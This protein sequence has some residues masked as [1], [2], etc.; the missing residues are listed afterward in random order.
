MSAAMQYMLEHGENSASYSDIIGP[1]TQ[2]INQME[3]VHG[4]SYTDL[5]V[6]VDSRVISV[7]DQDGKTHAYEF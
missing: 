5:T 7:V 3:P 6:N 1:N 2:Y 4:E